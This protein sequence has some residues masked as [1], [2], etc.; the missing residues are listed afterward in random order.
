MRIEI[1]HNYINI[2][3]NVRR[4]IAHNYKILPHAYQL[5][6]FFYIQIAYK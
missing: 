4:Q 2:D 3:N 5:A 1:A 6:T